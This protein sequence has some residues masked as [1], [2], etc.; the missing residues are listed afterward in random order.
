MI[1]PISEIFKSE[2]P[3][4]QSEK[5]NLNQ[6]EF[7]KFIYLLLNTILDTVTLTAALMSSWFITYLM[8]QQA[9]QSMKT[10]RNKRANQ[11]SLSNSDRII[12]TV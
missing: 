3:E 1:V 2:V 4:M 6:E 7:M 5:P 10:V 9:W 8:V 12:S 11:H